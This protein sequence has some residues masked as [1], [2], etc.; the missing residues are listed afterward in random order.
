MK[1]AGSYLWSSL[2]S[3]QGKYLHVLLLKQ[4]SVSCQDAAPDPTGGMVQYPSEVP[5]DLLK[6]QNTSGLMSGGNTS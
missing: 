1:L 6:F 3:D 2:N 4:H 5:H